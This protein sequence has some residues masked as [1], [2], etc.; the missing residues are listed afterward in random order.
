MKVI[1]ATGSVA[2]SLLGAVCVFAATAQAQSVTL[3]MSPGLWHNTMKYVGDGAKQMQEA[4]GGQM[5]QAMEEMKTMMANMP[6]EQRKM[7]E[8]AMAASGMSMSGDSVSLNN[9]AVTIDKNGIEAKQCVTPEDIAEGLLPEV[10]DDCTSTLTA[11]GKNRYKSTQTCAG[12]QSSTM[13]SDIVFHSKTHFTGTG[14]VQ[15]HINGQTYDVQMTLEGKWLAAD[16]GD[17][18]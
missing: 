6:P 7:M 2:T 1:S 15:Q 5:Q 14:R 17:I 12:E 16:C 18:E 10:N 3:D 8:D 11:L 4:Y 13:E 9:N